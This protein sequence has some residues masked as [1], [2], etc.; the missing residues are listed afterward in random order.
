MND[1][2]EKN[3]II[4][5]SIFSNKSTKSSDK[6]QCPCSDQQSI[7]PRIEDCYCCYPDGGMSENP[8]CKNPCGFGGTGTRCHK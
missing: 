2:C 3:I 6:N 4:T 7:K 5:I 8:N 1:N